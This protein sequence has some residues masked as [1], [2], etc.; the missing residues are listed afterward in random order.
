MTVP[1][2]LFVRNLI[3]RRSLVAELVRRDFEQRFVG[4]SA[5]W[6]WG[7]IHP[8]VLLFSYAF[9]FQVCL[10]NV[11]PKGEVT[12][13]YTLWLF[14]GF[15]PWMLFQET[16][17]RSATSLLE[18]SNL[19]TKTIFP[20]EVVSISIFLSSLLNHLL[21][22]MLVVAIVGL[23]LGH[24][25]FWMLLLPVY[26]LMIGLFAVG[27]GWIVSSLQVYIRD[28]AQVLTV[29]LT[30]WFWTTPILIDESY[31]PKRLRFL[32]RLNPFAFLVRGYRDR[33]LSFRLP[34]FGEFAIMLAYSL[35][36]FV[37]GG[38]FF[39]HMKRGFADVL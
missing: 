32:L 17:T 19:I 1:G 36:I 30:L 33:L 3:E 15:L 38:L 39:R 7:M 27:L 4:S 37:L 9:V 34:D 5:G 11:P 28:S 29:A 18:H 12:S 14:C 31:Y 16:L 24:L 26:M 23:W 22:L 13:N 35:L 10:H 21:A 20:A 8:L 6:L 25:S 2:R